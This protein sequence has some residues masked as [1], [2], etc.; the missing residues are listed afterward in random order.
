MYLYNDQ[1]VIF[2]CPVIIENS[3]FFELIVLHKSPLL[4]FLALRKG[5]IL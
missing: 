4:D 1:F 2:I 5:E 3:L